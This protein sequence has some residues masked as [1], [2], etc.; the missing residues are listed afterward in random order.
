MSHFW[1]NEYNGMTW[2]AATVIVAVAAVGFRVLRSLWRGRC[3][4]GSRTAITLAFLNLSLAGT[5]GVLLGLEKQGIHVLPSM[6]L[7]DVFAHA[8]VAALGWATMIAVGSLPRL[9]PMF[10]PAAMPDEST[11]TRTAWA[12]EIG[13]LLLF[14]GFVAWPPAAPIGTAVVLFTLAG[15]ATTTL[16]L[17]DNSRPAPRGLRR[18]DFG[19]LHALQSVAY[20]IACLVLAIYLVIVPLSELQLRVMTVYDVLGLLGF[21]GQLVI[22][23]Q[24]RLLPTV[25]WIQGYVGSGFEAPPLSQYDMADRRLQAMTFAAWTLGV[26]LLAGGGV[27]EALWTVSLAS[28]LLLL[29]TT[30]SAI[31]GVRVWRHAWSQRVL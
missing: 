31:N 14:V 17:R 1:L 3:P 25:A 29:A 8:H 24:M 20:L 28:A 30:A 5:W 23:V 22:G 12:L 18:P 4:A 6:I 15:L 10:L 26:P 27:L 16:R 19:V 13:V 21:L 7:P 11:G 2:S 9:L